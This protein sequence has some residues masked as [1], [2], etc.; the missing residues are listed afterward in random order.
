MKYRTILLALLFILLTLFACGVPQ[1]DSSVAVE[2]RLTIA[3]AA[4]VEP[5]FTEL[6]KQFE[7][8]TGVKVVFSFGATGNL[9]KQIENG[10]PFDLFAAA[11]IKT[12][13]SLVTKGQ[14][15]PSSKRIYAR[16]KLV[17]LSLPEAKQFPKSLEELTTL[18]FKKIGIANP[19]V[20]PYGAAA[21]ES[22]VATGVWPK[23]ENRIVYG[24]N[25][26][27]VYQYAKT[28]NIDL[29]FIPL[30]LVNPGEK[31]LIID[32]KLYKPIDQALGILK[33]STHIEVARE[34]DEF[35][36]SKKG[37]TT[38]EKFGYT[39]PEQ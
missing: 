17:L 15:L 30:S 20:A 27:I 34:F 36:A 29:A 28:G 24:D 38:L 31:F 12:I 16:G 11:D 13:D 8:E 2:K 4:N 22:L 21:K 19:E 9:A 18:E 35:L 26:G 33:S 23:I 3:A 39:L 7:T 10:A 14:I 25:V 5:V 1:K 37:Q 6:G 32:E